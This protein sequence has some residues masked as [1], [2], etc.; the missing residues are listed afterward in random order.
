MTAQPPAAF[1]DRDGCPIPYIPQ[2]DLEL[3]QDCLIP[4]A[5]DPIFEAPEIDP[6]IPPPNIGCPPIWLNMRRS[7]LRQVY[8]WIIPDRFVKPRPIVPNYAQFAVD[9]SYRDDDYCAPN[10]DIE[11]A[12]PEFVIPCPPFKLCFNDTHG[13][14]GQPDDCPDIDINRFKRTRK[15]EDRKLDFVADINFGPDC[16]IDVEVDVDIVV[17]CTRI[18]FRRGTQET[19]DEDFPKIEIV[20]TNNV[21]WDRC[22]LEFD[23]NAWV[24]EGGGTAD[25][26][27][28][29]TIVL[30]EGDMVTHMEMFYD[31]QAQFQGGPDNDGDGFGDGYDKNCFYLYIH[32]EDASRYARYC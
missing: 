29:P 19:W 21:N 28:H 1:R 4:E 5:P 12:M 24:P 30:G 15:F 10:I 8:S 13:P 27:I 20:P 14:Q 11:V 6:I 2:L 9:I 17:P 25:V 3:V 16:E 23:I 7:A 22:E 31:N 18:E 26:C 32:K